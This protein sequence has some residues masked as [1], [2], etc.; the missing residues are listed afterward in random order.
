MTLRSHDAAHTTVLRFDADVG[1]QTVTAFISHA[2]L[3]ARYGGI[4]ESSDDMRSI[5]SEHRSEIAA[6]IARRVKA[7]AR[8]P[9]VLLASDLCVPDQTEYLAS[10]C[11]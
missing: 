2:A 8:L 5:V 1:L 6:A 9:V 3:S 11:C 7:G 10:G 4:D